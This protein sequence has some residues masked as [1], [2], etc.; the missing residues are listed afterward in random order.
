M[1]IYSFFF[2]KQK[3]AYEM[4]ISD[5]SSDVCSSDLKTVG[6]IALPGAMTGL[7]LAGVDPVDA[8]LVQ[9]VVMYLIL[10]G[11]ATATAIVGV[12]GTRRLFTEDHRLVRLARPESCS[13]GKIGR[14]SCRERVCQYV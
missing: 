5:W 2:F 3:T 11:A 12:G 1:G 10:G 7:I 4:R 13:W 8:V 14:A 9:V 6:L